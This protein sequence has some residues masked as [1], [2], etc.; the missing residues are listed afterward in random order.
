MELVQGESLAARLEKEAR[1]DFG[2][3]WNI[4]RQ[5]L[6]ALD[7]CHTRG[8]Q[9]RDLK[10]ANIMVA[11]DDAIK[12]TDF[13][14]ARVDTSTLTQPGD[15]LGTLHYMAPEQCMGLACTPLTDVY[16]L[17]TGERPFDG[18]VAQIV[19]RILQQRAPNPSLIN[20][21]IS[22]QLDWVMQKALAKDPAARFQ[23]VR[24]F[25]DALRRNLERRAA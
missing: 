11:G 7:Y 3:V 2:V 8:V 9:H 15:A 18:E 1:R 6:E 19:R 5:V 13:G 23:S 25:S 20:P 12:I 14:V 17:L 22:P 24:E 21:R 16:E 10:P 4:A